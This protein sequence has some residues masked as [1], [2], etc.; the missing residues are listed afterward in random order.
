MFID[1][2]G[3]VNKTAV[4]GVGG[5]LVLAAALVF[6]GSPVVKLDQTELGIDYSFGK[7]TT[8]KTADLRQPGLNFKIPF[9][10]DIRRVKISQ[11][12]RN[13]E[14]VA[15]YTKDN[16]KITA[17]V[18]VFFRV[19]S[20][21]MLDIYKNNPDW[22]TKLETAIESSYKNALG[23]EEAQS[24]AQNREIIMSK[25]TSETKKEV[26]ELLGIEVTQ[27]LLPNYDFNKEFDIAVAD[28]ANAKAELSKKQTMLE[29]QKVDAMTAVAKANGERDSAKARAEG[30]AFA[31]EAT[32]SAQAKGALLL[33]EAEAKGFE[34][35]VNAIGRENMDAYLKTSKWKGE[36]SLVPMVSGSGTSTIVDARQ[37]A[38]PALGGP[39]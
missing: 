36:G 5:G 12:Q 20:D 2:N 38:I 24:V 15:T 8:E 16:Q 10:Q 4:I 29:Q 35:I 26:A 32:V 6:G 18:S 23:K 1:R 30:E 33:K 7:M 39:K 34:A 3:N 25:V 27:V 17:S 11:Q 19:P 37:A 21:K 14:A 9:V 13:Y 22:E 31:I 28:A